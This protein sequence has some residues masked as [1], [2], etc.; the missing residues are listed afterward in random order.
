MRTFINGKLYSSNTKKNLR[1]LKPLSLNPILSQFD[2]VNIFISSLTKIYFNM[3]HTSTR[4]SLKLSDPGV[5]SMYI[6]VTCSS[7]SFTFNNPRN[8]G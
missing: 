5:V 1:A 6:H 4:T 2:I 7:Q 3:T 8:S